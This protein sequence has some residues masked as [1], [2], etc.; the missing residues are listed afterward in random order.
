MIALAMVVLSGAMVILSGLIL[1]ELKRVN[2]QLKKI[3]N[4]KSDVHLPIIRK[5]KII[6]P[7]PRPEPL[8]AGR[9][10]H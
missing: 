1:I 9:E 5:G 2:D 10:L 3:N 4:Q 8:P 6:L 7:D